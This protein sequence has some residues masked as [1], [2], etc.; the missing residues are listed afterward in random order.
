MT[1]PTLVKTGE[2][3]KCQI[4]GVIATAADLDLAAG[5]STPPDLFELRLDHLVDAQDEVESRIGSLR[6]PLIIT[7]RHP[8]EG[9][10]HN[11]TAN[12]RRQLLARFVGHARYVDVELRSAESFHALLHS[13][14]NRSV[15]RILSLHDFDS[16]P[17]P[18]SLHAKARMAKSLGAS[19]FKVATR[20][21]TPEQLARLL[22]FMAHDD[23]GV[24]VSVMGV[25]KL[26]A[27]SRALLA[28]CGS[29]MAYAALADKQVEGQLSVPDLQETFRLLG[30]R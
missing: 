1:L 27:V 25:G 11:L 18:R 22:E 16:T 7:A 6:A 28:S 23:K 3:P 2:T 26:G 14:P 13:L 20:T 4:V 29:A 24:A 17:T 12:R 30:L 9:G 5:L 10:A 8:A 19:L 21:D 15:E